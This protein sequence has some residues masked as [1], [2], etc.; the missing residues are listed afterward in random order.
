LLHPE[1]FPVEVNQ[2]AYDELLRVPGIGP[3]SAKR[4]IALRAGRAFRDLRD[5]SLLGVAV[6]RA[7]QFLLL[8]GRYRGDRHLS[9]R[10]TLVRDLSPV[11]LSLWG[12]EMPLLEPV[13]A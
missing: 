12:D 5:L 11:Q 7:R 13:A 8:D 9:E 10:P 2:A 4:I 3:I 1:R 6:K